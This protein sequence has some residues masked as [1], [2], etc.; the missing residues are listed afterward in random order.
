MEVRLDFYWKYKRITIS[1]A[2]G[3]LLEVQEDYY[4]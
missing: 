2:I 3:L 4:W 1:S